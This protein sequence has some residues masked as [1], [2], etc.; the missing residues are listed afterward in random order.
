MGE[1]VYNKLVRDRIVE[2]IED[3]G[4]VAVFRTLGPEEMEDCLQS[5]LQEEVAEFLEAGTLDELADIIEVIY[6]L[7][8]NRGCNREELDS[9]RESKTHKRGGFT[10]RVFLEKVIGGVEP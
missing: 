9:I 10:Q 2:I 5:K 6:A 3:D 1:I 4:K 8:S 7:A